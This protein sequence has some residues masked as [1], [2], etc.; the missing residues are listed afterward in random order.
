MLTGLVRDYGCTY[1]YGYM[2][3]LYIC[4]MKDIHIE[5]HKD[6]M[7]Q[8]RNPP[9]RRSTKIKVMRLHDGESLIL[10]TRRSLAM[11]IEVQSTR[12]YCQL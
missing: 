4:G 1:F 7:A 10:T 11:G 8:E 6:E 2:T 12:T 9:Y 3:D 5:S